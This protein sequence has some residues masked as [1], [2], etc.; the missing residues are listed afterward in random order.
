[1]IRI[2]DIKIDPLSLGGQYLLADVQKSYLYINGEKTNE[3]DGFKYWVVLPNLKY[4]KIGIKVFSKIPLV[5]LEEKIP[6][7]TPIEFTNLVVGAYF[8][9]N[10]LTITA[11]AD[12]AHFI[13]GGEKK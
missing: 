11:H 12:A 6:T 8:Q 9:N 1:M 10:Q 3:L 13:A 2:Q 5:N 7:G 4:E